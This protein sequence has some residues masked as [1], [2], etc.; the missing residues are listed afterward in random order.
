MRVIGGTFGG[1]RL[2]TPRGQ[3]TRPTS[4]LVRGAIFNS[5]VARGVIEDATVADLFAGSGAL[6]IEAMSR[7][8]REVVFVDS[9]REAAHAITA[10]LEALGVAATVVQDKVERWAS[11]PDRAALD[12]ILADPPYGWGGWD[13]L[14]EILVTF[15]AGFVVAEAERP[16]EHAGW[17]VVG[18]GHHGDTVVTQL[19]QRGAS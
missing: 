8:A 7:G 3:K 10:N 15:P 12:V 9:S 2:V 6:G 5:L 14:L 11:A 16:I 19:A 1:R 4:E 17:D 13:D 18:V